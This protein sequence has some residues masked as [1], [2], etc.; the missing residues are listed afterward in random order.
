MREEGLEVGRMPITAVGDP[1]TNPHDSHSLLLVIL[2]SKY[3][4]Q[5][6]GREFSNEG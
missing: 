1:L 6:R 3:M 4:E 2:V 5:V